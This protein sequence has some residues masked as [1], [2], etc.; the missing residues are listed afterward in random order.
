MKRKLKDKHQI[1]VSEK[2]RL[3]W[4]NHF[5]TED[6]SRERKKKWTSAI[7]L[8]DMTSFCCSCLKFCWKW[9]FQEFYAA[10][11]RWKL[12]FPGVTNRYIRTLTA[13]CTTKTLSDIHR[14][15]FGPNIYSYVA[16]V[17]CFSCPSYTFGSLF[18]CSFL[19]SLD[20]EQ[21][22]KKKNLFGC[23]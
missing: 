5:H 12:D 14:N 19:N 9:D 10:I 2:N 17:G 18:H 23:L 16:V 7:A 21:K 6:K 1:R 15:T 8:P 13:C 11:F 4:C 22:Q 20:F 3:C